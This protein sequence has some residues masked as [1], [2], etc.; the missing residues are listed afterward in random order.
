[1]IITERDIERVRRLVWDPRYSTDQ[2]SELI[3]V[4]QQAR[5]DRIEAECHVREMRDR[6]ARG[7]V[8][9]VEL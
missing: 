8:Q 3:G 5:E 4:A 9:A 2:V 6:I 1:V 7:F